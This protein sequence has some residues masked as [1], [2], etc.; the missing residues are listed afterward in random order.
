MSIRIALRGGDDSRLTDALKVT[1]IAVLSALAVA[2]VGVF[3]ARDQMVRHRRDLF[4]PHPLRRLAALGYLRQHPE[5]YN[6]MLLRDFLAWEDRPLLRKR[7]AAILEE[8]EEELALEAQRA[9]EEEEAGS[10]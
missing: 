5:V 9:E 1:G 3:V 7:A 4:S 6:V 8:M 2:A 10:A